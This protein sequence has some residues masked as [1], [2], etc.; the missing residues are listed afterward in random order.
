MTS[1]IETRRGRAGPPLSSAGW[2]RAWPLYPLLL[3]IVAFFVYP[4]LQ[5][6]W[7]SLVDRAGALTAEHYLRLVD[8]AGVRADARR[9][10]FK[11]SA[12]TTAL[13]APCR[14]PGRLPP[15]DGAPADPGVL[16]L[17]VLLPFWT[18]F[19]VRT[20]AWIVLLGR[21][22]A[23]NQLAARARHHRRAAVADLQLHRHDDRH[24]ARADAARRADH[25]VGDGAA[26][27]R[28]CGSA[29]ATLGARGGSAFWR[30][31]FPLSLPGVAAAGLLVFIT[32]L[33]FFITPALL[34][35]RRET[36]ISQ[37]IIS[38]CRSC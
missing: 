14:L 38:R 17:L 32:A 5:I 11:I 13:L 19:L 23:V 2:V 21:N 33:G 27:T 9:S 36:M 3:L 29:A 1:A 35:G 28:P 31:Y 30:I 10:R 6:L 8:D 24:G 18:S 12:W 20:F 34:G 16:T 22:G 7:L 25:A 26:S 37:V 4:V 15:R